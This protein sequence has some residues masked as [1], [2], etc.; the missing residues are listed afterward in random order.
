MF[1]KTLPYQSKV[2]SSEIADL[3]RTLAAATCISIQEMNK[4]GPKLLYL[5][6][7]FEK[8]NEIK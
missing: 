8:L 6:V 1:S 5:A 7:E 2:P 4:N 3:L